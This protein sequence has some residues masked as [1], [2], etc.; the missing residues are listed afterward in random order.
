[1]RRLD[2]W[3]ARRGKTGSEKNQSQ[4]HAATPWGGLQDDDKGHGN[5]GLA[6]SNGT[7]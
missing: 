1:M 2:R 4:A 6:T 3:R 7:E 5:S